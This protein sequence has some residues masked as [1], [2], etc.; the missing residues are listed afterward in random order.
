MVIKVI[1]KL[2]F[3]GNKVK[4]KEVKIYVISGNDR[5]KIIVSF[6]EEGLLDLVIFFKMF[7]ILEYGQC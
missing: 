1:Y 6:D 4:N 7:V 2:K 5:Q 3:F